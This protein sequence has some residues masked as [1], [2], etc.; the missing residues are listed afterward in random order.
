MSIPDLKDYI[1]SLAD[2]QQRIYFFDNL[3]TPKAFDQLLKMG[4]FESPPPLH[5]EGERTYTPLWPQARYLIN[6]AD[7]IPESVARVIQNIETDNPSVMMDL[8]RAILK[9]PPRVARSTA[10]R[11]EQWVGLQGAGLLIF[12]VLDIIDLLATSVTS[13]GDRRALFRVVSAVLSVA[14]GRELVIESF[15]YRKVDA[16]GVV[17][18]NHYS[19]ALD[20]I[21]KATASDYPYLTLR[22]LQGKLEEA[23]KIENIGSRD[24]SSIWLPQLAK[25][26]ITLGPKPTLAHRLYSIGLNAI[27]QQTMT[28]IE[29]F[30]LL[31]QATSAI[32]RRIKLKIIVD[33]GDLDA[34]REE[35]GDPRFFEDRD[36]V[37]ERA[38]LLKT[39]Y[40][41]LTAEEQEAV[42]ASIRAAVT[43]EAIAR[44]HLAQQF[45]GS[46]L[47]DAVRDT[48]ERELYEELGPIS[49]DLDGAEAIE[50]AELDKRFH[51]EELG[52]KDGEVWVGPTAPVDGQELARM[53]ARDLLQYLKTWSP[54]PGW[55]Q[56]TAEG[57]GRAIEPIVEARVADFLALPD[58][59][60]ELHPIYVRHIVSALTKHVY[61]P[62]FEFDAFLSILEYAVVRESDA[63]SGAFALLE[64]P[65][66]GPSW[67]SALQITAFAVTDM[68]RTKATP[69]TL[70]VRIWNVLSAVLRSPD[71]SDE[72]D[73]KYGV[74]SNYG[75]PWQLAL[76]SA[77]G[78]GMRALFDYARWIYSAAG[79]VEKSIELVSEAPEV[80]KEIDQRLDPGL[81]RTRAIRST[82]GQNFV[83]LFAM[84]KTWVKSNT[85]RIFTSDSLGDATWAAYLAHNSVYDETFETLRELYQ[86][87]AGALSPGEQPAGS[88]G[89]D[90]NGNL[91]IHLG[92]VYARG[93]ISLQGSLL[94]EFIK[95]APPSAIGSMLTSMGNALRA[96]GD[97]S[98]EIVARCEGLYA[99]VL[100]ALRDNDEEERVA[101]L[102]NFGLWFQSRQM[103]EEWLLDNL[104]RTLKRT[105]GRIAWENMVFERLAEFSIHFPQQAAE[106][107]YEMT[108]GNYSSLF[109]TEEPIGEILRSAVRAGGVPQQI[110]IRANDRLVNMGILRY[111]E[112]FA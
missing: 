65:D 29:V 34:A 100:S 97:L 23:L 74:T 59:I 82:I 105:K 83:S 88:W 81:E 99:F 20:R 19:F 8:C 101:A 95:R 80:F 109:L 22:T 51:A 31:D 50:Y 87:A 25:K 54:T 10:F 3:K 77:R 24:L 72:L 53:S 4:V 112:L 70:R 37:P 48:R 61:A 35:L 66:D 6:V 108:F 14:P 55:F 18:E 17:G 58:E 62:D 16:V 60:R 38:L 46:E 64:D 30:A 91:G 13:K 1:A 42:I 67:S 104:I 71:P 32:Y 12:P 52:P 78:A 7:S 27:A 79:G 110:A 85:G 40:T 111:N 75:P 11:L 90:I 36:L 76:N 103:S 68:L 21:E 86:R 57:L 33:L 41:R 9:M 96:D 84:S 106:A 49:E 43:P 102:G 69:T 93:L 89:T 45:A 107:L 56:P 98:A 2:P 26:P 5:M 28:R 47:D 94:E 92:T 63:E 39:F 15:G 73:S 44:G